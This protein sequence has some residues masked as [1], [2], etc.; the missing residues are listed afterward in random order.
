MNVFRADDFVGLNREDD[1]GL[2]SFTYRQLKELQWSD[3]WRR[4]C[5]GRT[6]HKNQHKMKC[7]GIQTLRAKPICTYP[8]GIV[9]SDGRKW[10]AIQTGGW[11]YRC[12]IRQPILTGFERPMVNN[13]SIVPGNETEKQA[14]LRVGIEA[15]APGLNRSPKKV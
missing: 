12:T 10:R 9:L 6:V 8:D 14:T 7:L 11:G 5:K 3:P 15:L 13:F 4:S 2:V 1:K